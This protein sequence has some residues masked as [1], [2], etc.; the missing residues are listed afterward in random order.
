MSGMAD[1]MAR[2]I[3]ADG[4]AEA[5]LA[6]ARDAG[7]SEG[8]EG[9]PPAP[10]PPAAA[11][12]NTDTGADGRTPETIPYGRFKEVNDQLAEL[13]PYSEFTK[14][15]Y[16]PDSLGRLV[17]FEASYQQ[18]PTGTVAFLVD[19]LDLPSGVKGAVRTLLTNEG[20]PPAGDG[21]G[22][23][24]EDDTGQ[25][26]SAEMKEALEYYRERK[27]RDE[28]DASNQQLDTALGHWNKLDAED[29]IETPRHIQL[30]AI[31]SVAGSGQ[32]ATIE[33]LANA[34]RATIVDYRDNL[35]GSAVVPR[36]RGGSPPAV[37]PGPPAAPEQPK[38]SSLKE[39]S[40][41]ALEDMK[42]GRLPTTLIEQ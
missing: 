34:A 2:R 23:P 15:G 18:D 16:D 21:G 33:D 12:L 30:M 24:D 38:F 25:Q 5:A 29:K 35:L 26:M 22:T 36:N 9:V 10:A 20:T 42:A 3:E 1:E 4:G 8:T 6:A 32:F 27:A 28:T 41:A 19:N 31:S 14:L 40:K 11:P 37:P 13:R 17:N 7:G 39:A